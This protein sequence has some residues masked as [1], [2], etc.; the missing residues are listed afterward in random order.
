MPSHQATLLYIPQAMMHSSRL[1]PGGIL[2]ISSSILSMNKSLMIV[3]RQGHSIMHQWLAAVQR[4]YQQM[5]QAAHH[6]WEI[7]IMASAIRAQGLHSI[8]NQSIQAVCSSRSSISS[9][10][11]CCQQRV[12]LNACRAAV[13]TRLDAAHVRRSISCIQH[14]Q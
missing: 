4:A 13:M 7:V 8:S 11:M 14:L 1:K 2:I 10:S 5:L 12:A 9:S 3:A 6:R